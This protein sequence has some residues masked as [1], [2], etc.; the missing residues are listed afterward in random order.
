MRVE[1]I[2]VDLVFL[3]TTVAACVMLSVALYRERGRVRAWFLAAP[4]LA[5]VV[6]YAKAGFDVGGARVAL[7]S[8]GVASAFAGPLG[9]V[10]AV[11]VA[12]TGPSVRSDPALRRMR[13]RAGAL[14]FGVVTGQWTAMALVIGD[15]SH[16]VVFG[17]GGVIAA[18]LMLG[19]E[20][21]ETRIDTWLSTHDRPVAAALMGAIASAPVLLTVAVLSMWT[22]SGQFVAWSQV[23]LPH[24]VSLAVAVFSG[25]AALWQIVKDQ[26]KPGVAVAAACGFVTPLA[27]IWLTP[28]FLDA[29]TVAVALPVVGVWAT[30]GLTML[31]VQ[32]ALAHRVATPD[33]S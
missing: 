22:P 31:V 1:R 23:L 6:V 32:S 24:T 14:V 9:M 15:W 12:A 21:H 16:S 26:P 8:A 7:Y 2:M 5:F 33:E 10:A 4:V 29:R 19:L 11:L 17:L 27:L 28:G 13:L 20:R 25:V 30:T 3:A 18:L